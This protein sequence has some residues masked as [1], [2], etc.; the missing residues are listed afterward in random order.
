L[1][2]R[3]LI[4]KNQLHFEACGRPFFREPLWLKPCLNIS[5]RTVVTGLVKPYT[6]ILTSIAMMTNT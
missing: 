4:N 2:S 1:L 3:W 6:L 5:T